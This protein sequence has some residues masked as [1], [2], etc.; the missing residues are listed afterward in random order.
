MGC[1]RRN[2]FKRRTARAAANTLA[3][4][5]V[6]P[7]DKYFHLVLGVPHTNTGALGFSGELVAI[8]DNPP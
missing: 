7:T 6:W 2:I 3:F 5:M 8:R 1:K 4:S